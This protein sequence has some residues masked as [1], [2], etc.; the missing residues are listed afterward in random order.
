M[1]VGALTVSCSKKEAT[2][3]TPIAADAPATAS[4]AAAAAAA[5]QPAPPAS[6]DSRAVDARIAEAQAAMKARD[7]E[8]AATA[9]AIS[10]ATPVS[11]TAQQL[12]SINS[13]KANMVNQLSAAA[14][15]GDPKAKATLEMLRQRALN[16]Q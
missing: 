13:E 15:A 3:V 9:L 2:S 12:M 1:L 8:R 4:P 7:Y 16:H 5:T 6:G 14:A 11:M 10:R